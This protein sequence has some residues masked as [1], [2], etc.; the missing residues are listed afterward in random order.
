M[1]RFPFK[2]KNEIEMNEQVHAH[3]RIWR[4]RGMEQKVKMIHNAPENIN[5]MEEDQNEII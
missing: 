3:Q 4:E 1:Y 5:D 2:C